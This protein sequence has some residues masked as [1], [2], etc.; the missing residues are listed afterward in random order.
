[1]KA[2]HRSLFTGLTPRCLAALA[3]HSLDLAVDVTVAFVV[4]VAE[5]R[6]LQY[7]IKIVP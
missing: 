2:F 3:C 1:M 6:R 4:A 5:D 7:I